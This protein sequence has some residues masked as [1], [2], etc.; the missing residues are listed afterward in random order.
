MS[1]ASILPP[2][3]APVSYSN[4]NQSKVDKRVDSFSI[5]G[6]MKSA[7]TK[8]VEAPVLP[9]TQAQDNSVSPQLPLQEK[10]FTQENL[11]YFWENFAKRYE[12]QD[13]R[14][15]HILDSD[16]IQLKNETE[17]HLGLFNSL[18]I[19]QFERVKMQLLNYLVS[20]LENRKISIIVYLV[21]SADIPK[22]LTINEKYENMVKKNSQ[23]K[24]FKDRLN[25]DF[26]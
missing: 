2:Q 14:L 13:V 17:V 21:E 7:T 24:E 25:L 20:N 8:A 12:S 11:V 3:S 1:T 10:N 22:P 9:P 19:E 23:L 18:Q 16:K 4:E 15:F 6:A 5:K 26:D